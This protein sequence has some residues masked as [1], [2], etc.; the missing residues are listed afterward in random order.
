[1]GSCVD[2]GF[3]R[4]TRQFFDEASNLAKDVSLYAKYAAIARKTFR[5]GKGY[6]RR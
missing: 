6:V 5:S 1:M 2:S 3:A 4:P